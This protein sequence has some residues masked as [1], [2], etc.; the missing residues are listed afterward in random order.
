MQQRL[1]VAGRN[2][3]GFEHVL[4]LSSQA[5]H[6]ANSIGREKMAGEMGKM[7]RR[8]KPPNNHDTI[9]SDSK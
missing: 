4:I 8:E 2:F 7:E 9:T 5:K 1:G 6:K 3:V